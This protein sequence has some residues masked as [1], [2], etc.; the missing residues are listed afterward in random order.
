MSN[1][2]SSSTPLRPYLG[3]Q[4]HLSL[5]WLSQSLLSL[6]LISITLTLLLSNINHLVL[7]GKEGFVSSCQGVQG[8]ANVLVSLPHYMADG[9]NELNR[10]SVSVVTEGAA[11]ILDLALISVEEIVL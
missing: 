7:D 9:V 8:A 4:A 6:I 2:P 11:G 10:K 5:S 3:S 1:L